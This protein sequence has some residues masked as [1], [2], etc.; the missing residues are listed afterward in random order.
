MSLLTFCLYVPFPVQYGQFGLY[1]PFPDMGISGF[2]CG[3][4]G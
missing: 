4:G 2:R 1:V 3:G